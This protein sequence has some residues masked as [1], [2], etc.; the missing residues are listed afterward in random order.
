[1]KNS[2]IIISILIFSF[3][4]TFSQFINKNITED[5]NTQSET[6][7][8]I[9]P[10]NS[11]VLLAV[12]NDFQPSI[13]NWSVAGYS[14]TQDLF[15]TK[16]SGFRRPVGF[17]YSYDP[18]AA[19]DKYGNA[20]YCYIAT[21]GLHSN[22]PV[23]LSITTD[24]GNFWSDIQ[25]SNSS[26][27]DKP[28]LTIDNTGNSTDG[29]IYVSWSDHTN[30][31]QSIHF[32]YSSDNGSTFLSENEIVLDEILGG[33]GGNVSEDPEGFFVDALRTLSGSI[34]I[35]LSNG[36]LIVV[37]LEVDEL[38]DPKG[39]IWISR[40]TDGGESFEDKN[41]VTNLDFYEP[42]PAASINWNASIPFIAADP[43]NGTIYITYYEYIENE[44]PI[45]IV[46]S[47]DEGS[48]WTNPQNVINFS[49]HNSICQPQVSVDKNSKISIF[50]ADYQSGGFFINDKYLIESFD[51]GDNFLPP[52]KVT[53]ETSSYIPPYLPDYQGLSNTLAGNSYCIWTDSRPS[54]NN[55]EIYFSLAN[56]LDYYASHYKTV[57]YNATGVNGSRKFVKD[58]SEVYHFVFASGGNIY[59][60]KSANRGA[61]WSTPL[62]ISNE[63]GKN[64]F[65]SI[66]TKGNYI[67]VIYYEYLGIENNLHK[68]IL[69][70]KWKSLNSPNWISMNLSDAEI[71]LPILSTAIIPYPTII[72]AD[73]VDNN[74][75][76]SQG[77]PEL[78]IAFSG[79]DGMDHI[80]L[81]YVYTE[82]E[83]P[84][85][86]FKQLGSIHH[87]P[88][89]F[90]GF[91][92][93]SIDV[94]TQG[95]IMLSC[96]YNNNIYAYF[97]SGGTWSAISSSV[98]S[99]TYVKNNKKSS[100]TSDAT[101]YFHISWQGE[102][103]KYESSSVLHKKLSVL[104]GPGSPI[105]EFTN[106]QYVSTQPS[107]F[108]HMDANGGVS[109]YWSTSNDF[110]IKRVINDGASWDYSWNDF[111]PSI[112]SNAKYVNAINK[113]SPIYYAYCWTSTGELPVAY[114]ILIND[115]IPEGNPR[116]VGRQMNGSGDSTKIYRSAELKVEELDVILAPQ[117]G[118][119]KLVT[120]DGECSPLDLLF[121]P[122]DYTFSSFNDILSTL[123]CDT[124]PASN[125]YRKISFDYSLTIKNLYKIKANNSEN[126]VCKLKF[127]D[128]QTGNYLNTI[129]SMT[130]PMDSITQTISGNLIIPFNHLNTRYDLGLSVNLEGIDDIYMT[131]TENIN[132]LN[133]YFTSSSSLNKMNP[134]SNNQTVAEFNLEQNYP[135]PFNPVTKIKFDIPKS[136]LISLKVYDVLGREIKELVNE[137]KLIGN[138][139][140]NFDASNYTSG[141]YFYKLQTE[142]FVQTKKMILLK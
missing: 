114:N 121:L 88:N 53:T 133:T 11:S 45:R 62:N 73:N 36:H 30:G 137:F 56:S 140:V 78:M 99:S 79:D 130:L 122:S 17:T 113:D 134:S 65:P 92:N 123:N 18:S 4:N 27:C 40:S 136:S 115:D 54:N 49:N 58:M 100:I 3:A 61:E 37:W 47:S 135:N 82:G 81:F 19:F 111:I 20:F 39:S 14:F 120:K 41:L 80:N 51:G 97:T 48:T 33:T 94:N 93:P 77:A 38:D 64:N 116:L 105:T 101:G 35:V 86:N 9:D 66:A 46:K 8:A 5:S 89:T 103:I 29:R 90:Y 87:I 110:S 125:D 96:D 13:N 126:I 138:Y 32:N 34:P 142:G 31:V 124:I 43:Q 44:Y 119:I 83:T 75:N 128:R 112:Q 106:N 50:F 71:Y 118:N 63:G 23:Y 132:L 12:W 108:G 57:N 26:F 52:I 15:E 2:L 85:Y 16:T 141:V 76:S 6:M 42:P 102:N 21:S 22:G 70:G 28:W 107:T 98:F 55:M 131:Q 129:G 109:I 95:Q 91:N 104:G 60:R 7:I 67:F 117:L 127:F 1:M 139:E 72:A 10:L 69:R 24:L 25:V 59:Y 74:Y 84:E 68:Y